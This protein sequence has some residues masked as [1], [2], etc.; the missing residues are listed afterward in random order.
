M[1][2]LAIL[3]LLVFATLPPAQTV[4]AYT[5]PAGLAG[6]VRLQSRTDF[7]GTTVRI[8]G[9]AVSTAGDGSFAFPSLPVGTYSLTAGRPGYVSAQR[10][11]VAIA[12]GEI[13]QLPEIL[14][15]A[16]D[17]DGDDDIDLFDLVVLGREFGSP[18]SKSPTDL[19][20]DNQ[21]N[22]FDLV[23][24]A[25][26]YGVIGPVSWDEVVLPTPTPTAT[27]TPTETPIASPTPTLTPSPTPTPVCIA[28]EDTIYQVG[29]T[30]CVRYQVAQVAK[31]GTSLYLYAHRPGS[32][33]ISFYALLR[34]DLWR[35]WPPVIEDYFLGKSIRVQGRI[36]TS[37]AYPHIVLDTCGQLLV[38]SPATPTSV[39]S[40]GPTP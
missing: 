13:T 19:N 40:P 26:N 35:C 8:A 38:E 33:E 11:G 10:L 34:S 9:Q 25:A 36:T 4:F 1:G 16:G 21:V 37:R 3:C 28:P 23:I 18:P 12:T 7:S 20:A 27:A 30:A 14:I 22:I 17:I 39:A 15:P 29:S 24:L 32:E 31:S 6:R 5:T 2:M